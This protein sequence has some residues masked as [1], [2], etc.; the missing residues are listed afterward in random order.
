MDYSSLKQ[1]YVGLDILRIVSAFVVC[2]FHTTIHLSCDFGI[3]QGFFMHG[4][5]FMT[6]F[7]MLSGF[8][9]FVNGGG[10]H[11]MIFP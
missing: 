2:I 7:F 11:L 10:N 5:V 1:R 4:A 3:L 8:T 9:L 6:A